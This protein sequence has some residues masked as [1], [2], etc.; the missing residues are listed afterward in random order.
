M[1]A[2]LAPRDDR[3]RPL[4]GLSELCDLGCRL[5]LFIGLGSRCDRH[6]KTLSSSSK[7][8]HSVP[9]FTSGVWAASAAIRRKDARLLKFYIGGK[10]VEPRNRRRSR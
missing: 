10:W 2:E 5:D 3:A 8:G 9:P 6:A 1:V 7:R 4:S